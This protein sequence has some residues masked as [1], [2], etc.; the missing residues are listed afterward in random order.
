MTTK[1]IK[2][3]EKI[4]KWFAY[5]G[6]ATTIVSFVAYGIDCFF[7]GNHN[8]IFGFPLLSG[9]ISAILGIGILFFTNVVFDK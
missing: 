2:I 1:I 3:A 9:I 6:I 5:I 7:V 8:S 4:G